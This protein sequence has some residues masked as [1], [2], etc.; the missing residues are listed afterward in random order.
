MRLFT[1]ALMLSLAGLA[2]ASAQTPTPD[3]E[4]GR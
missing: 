4:N 3:S 1:L 2:V